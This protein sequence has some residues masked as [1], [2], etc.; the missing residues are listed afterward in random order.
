MKFFLVDRQGNSK[1]PILRSKLFWAGVAI[2]LLLAICFAS[3][4]LRDLFAPFA[5]YFISSGFENPYAHFYSNGT[6]T[7][8][9]Y[10]PLMLW[11]FSSFS[12]LLYPFFGHLS[13]FSAVDSLLYRL[14]L[15]F[16][17]LAILFVLLRWLKTYTREVLVWYWLS[18]I[19][20]YIN[21]FHGQLDVI[22]MAFLFGSMYFLFK[23]KWLSSVVFLAFAI[24][25]K[26][27]MLLVLPF[28]AI[29]L[30]KIPNFTLKSALGAI[31]VLC[32]V[33]F[34]VNLPYIGSDGFMNMVYN[35]PVQQQVF[36]LYY[37][38]DEHLKFFFIP[39]VYF[40]LVLYY[41]SFKFVNRDQLIL[42]LAFTFL[43][44]T[45][46]I[47]PMQGWYYWVVPFLVF[48]IIKQ[49]PKVKMV[50]VMLTVLY[51]LYFALIPHSDF[52]S[53]FNFS[54]SDYI[55]NDNPLIL[56]VAFSLF[57]T[58]LILTGFLIFR[59]GISTNMQAKFLSQPYMIGIGGDSASGKSTLTS[60][61]VSI[62]ESHNTEV[63]RGDDMHKWERG[64]ENWNSFTHLDPKANKLHEDYLHALSLKTGN[65]VKR[66][67]YDHDTGE[68]ALPKFIKPNKLILFEGLH[69]FYLKNQ[70]DIYD[71]K[72]FMEPSE[73]LRT[74]WKVK[75]DV[76]KRGYAPS[77]VLEQIKKRQEDSIKYIRSQ[78]N[79][80]DLKAHFFSKKELNPLD[81]DSKP[82]LGLKISISNSMNIDEVLERLKKIETLKI[83]H[84]YE[85]NIQNITFFGNVSKLEIDNLAYRLLP[86]LEEIGVYNAE[87]QKDFDG[88]VQLFVVFLVF[89]KME[90]NNL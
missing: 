84:E 53:S 88:I 27:N 28:F 62:F 76:D 72:I 30:F 60:A 20:I 67:F 5:N 52:L 39:S 49:G 46:M 6:G 14:P 64:N 9:P 13:G 70:S 81:L 7:E 17:D 55:I 86:Q 68:F 2:K 89:R 61:L 29:Y 58:T 63:I 79:Q 11:V 54:N 41:A 59:K 87:W 56:N 51:F 38:F 19:L 45:L 44:L 15:F 48:F 74:W 73:E 32:S 25:C 31:F 26:T 22:P 90:V 78:A 47:A 16:A 36:N 35:N 23:N 77:Q 40:V 8:F 43:I 34:L 18:P 69:S 65:K 85:D 21:Y 3:N 50:F 83:S 33:I 12:T 1:L 24:G 66:S 75:R 37:Q 4:Y 80:A 57:Q 10:P 42:F 82:D 71:F